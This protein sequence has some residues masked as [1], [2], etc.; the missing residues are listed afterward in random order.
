MWNRLK[1][2]IKKNESLYILCQLIAKFKNK[3]FREMIMAYYFLDN[4]KTSL[5]FKHYGNE[6]AGQL[7]CLIENG[8]HQNSQHGFFALV[9]YTLQDLYFSDEMSLQPYIMW[10]K[11]TKYF[12]PEIEDQIQNV[13]EYYFCSISDIS[14]SSIMNSKNVTCV[15]AK[16]R[17]IFKKVY[18]DCSTEYEL[19]DIEIKKLAEVYK[20][21]FH[22]NQKT[23]E[24]IYC[25]KYELLKNQKTLGIHVR[26]TDFKEQWKNHPHFSGFQIY[27]DE[28][29]KV[30]KKQNYDKIFLAT[31]DE[32]ALQLFRKEYGDRLV[33]YEDIERTTG[34]VG[35]HSKEVDRKFHHYKLGLEILRDVYTLTAC[36][37][38]ITGLSQV[39]FAARYIKLSLGE[40]YQWQ[41][42]V[43]MKINEKGEKT[44]T[45][46]RDEHR[47][48]I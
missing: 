47:K 42:V 37:G 11:H 40:E 45:Q 26:G 8:V 23:Q 29:N 39:S 20:K 12:E 19:S 4:D 10:G 46:K 38:I 32:E 36:E 44:G 13:F 34:T 24:Y 48:N 17:S 2:L 9:R 31:D 18:G 28:C 33:Y 15:N 3:E 41:S 16:N 27:L 1:K 25:D 22:L 30:L 6:N 5:I 14:Y 7:I 43:Q 35:V 21:Y